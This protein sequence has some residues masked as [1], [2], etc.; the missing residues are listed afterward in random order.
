MGLIQFVRSTRPD[1]KLAQ[2]LFRHLIS[3]LTCLLAPLSFF[4]SDLGNRSLKN[5]KSFPNM[6][7]RQRNHNHRRKTSYSTLIF[8]VLIMFTF[9]IL[10]L[11]ALGIL[12]LPTNNGGSSKANDLTSIVR[13][14]L[15]R[16]QTIPIQ[17]KIWRVIFIIWYSRRSGK[18]VTEE[19]ERWVEIISWE[20]R[21]S[22]YH[23]F[24]V[25][26]MYNCLPNH[27]LFSV[28]INN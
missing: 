15:Q 1:S 22:I 4:L 25:S 23:N 28:D 10:F 2:S 16:Y 8:T 6:M 24:L 21:A 19:N 5:L 26:Y 7:A 20:P 18:D 27:L 14:N 12:S 9:L 11:L 3:P 13:K 17:Y